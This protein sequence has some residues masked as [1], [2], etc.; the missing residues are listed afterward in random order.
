M[1]GRWRRGLSKTTGP[2]VDAM[3]AGRTLCAGLCGRDTD[4]SL[5]MLRARPCYQ[6]LWRHFRTPEAT[7]LVIATRF[8]RMIA[9]RI[10][11]AL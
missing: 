7:A 5:L 1:S 10:S 6:S 2:C 8:L 9:G 11:Q 4:S 3:T